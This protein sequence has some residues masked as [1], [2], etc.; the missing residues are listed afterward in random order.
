MKKMLRRIYFMNELRL[1]NILDKME[2]K[3][4]PQ[5]IITDP[6][7]IF[8]LTGRWIHPGERLIALYISR[9]KCRLVINKLFPVYEDLGVEKLWYSDT[10]D[11]IGILSGVTDHNAPLGVDKNLAARFLLPL[12]DRKSA[13]T[14]VNGSVFVDEARASKDEK[15]R[16]LMAIASVLNDKG[17]ERFR[18]LVKPGVTEREISEQLEKIYQE[19]GAE[20]HSF[21]PIVCFGAN[22][23]DPHHEPDDTPLK[24]GDTVLF[25]VGCKKDSYCADMTRT[26]FYKTVPSEEHRKV[27]ELVKKAN[28]TA[29]AMIKPGVPL[30]DIDKAARDVIA[31]AGYGEQFTHRLG[32]FIGIDVH[33]FGDVSSANKNVAQVGNIF[34]IE[35]GIYLTG[36]VGVRIEDLVLVTEDGCRVLNSYPKELQIIK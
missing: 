10:D 28:E 22:C 33:D 25:D 9:G 7:S 23:A 13:K 16:E 26:F 29:E 5:M 34:S 6:A 31:Q 4:I 36:N 19:L 2:H 35:P 21:P 1:K 3:G 14:Y 17:M 15:E 20:G 12:M 27:Y 32:H 24:E 8:Y 30:C 18:Q 11:Y